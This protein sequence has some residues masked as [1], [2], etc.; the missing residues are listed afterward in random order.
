MKNILLIGGSTGIGYELSQK[1]KEDNNIFIST[2]NQDK[3]NHPNIKTNE[4]DLDKE[5][6]TDW[7]PEHLDGFIYLPGTINLRPFKGL[8]PTVFLEDFNINVM[9]C[10]TILQKVL[11]KIQAAENPSIVMFSTVAVKIGMPFHSSV[12]SSKGAIEG[13]TRSLA[14][15]FAPKIRVNAIAPSIL[16]TPLAEKFLNSETKLENSRNRHP[17]KEIGSPKDISEV[18]KF[19]LED[20]SKWMTGQIIPFDGGMSSVKTN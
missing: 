17:M 6:E 15:E 20:N 5:F 12:S 2:R 13:L 1:L 16:D 14:A 8:K 7:L 19:L 10:V 9:G 11:P 3:F 4:L 18:V